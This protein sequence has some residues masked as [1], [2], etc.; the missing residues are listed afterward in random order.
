MHDLDYSTDKHI[1]EQIELAFL[2]TLEY[3]TILYC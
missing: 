1:T 3:W 2:K